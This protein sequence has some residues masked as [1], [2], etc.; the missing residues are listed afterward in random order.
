[1][2]DRLATSPGTAIGQAPNVDDPL[3]EGWV[4]RELPR[5]G[6]FI[7]PAVPPPHL[8]ERVKRRIE[9]RVRRELEGEAR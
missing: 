1:M 7:G 4:R 9:A 8:V 5:G 2:T 3:P 6:V